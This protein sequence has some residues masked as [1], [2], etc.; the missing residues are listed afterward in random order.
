MIQIDQLNNGIK[1]VFET[2]P[3][4]RSVAVGI[5]IKTG[6]IYEQE[7]N[8]G[9]SHFI[10]HM[11]FKGTKKRSAKVIAE[12]MSAIG[13]HMNAFTAKEY[14][15]FYA[16]TLDEHIYM[17]LD[18]LSDMLQ[19]SLFAEEEI[20]KESTVI[21]DE[22]DM[23]ED[24][25]EEIAHD[26]FQ[27][28]IWE[29]HAL[30]YNI[31][32]KKETVESLDR[33]ELLKYFNHYYNVDNIVISVAGCFDPEEIKDTLNKLFTHVPKAS[34]IDPIDVPQYKRSFAYKDK[35]IEQVHVCLGYPSITYHSE[36]LYTQAIL[37]TILG[38]SMNSKLFQAIREEKGLA[39]SIYSYTSTYCNTGL[40]NIYAASNPAYV[41]D[42][43]IQ[44]KEEVKKLKLDGI[45]ED[46][47]NKT[48]EQLKSNYIIGLESTNSRMSSN[49]KAM[50]TLNRIKTQDEILDQL[51]AVTLND[52]QE[53]G[54]QILDF[55]KLSLSVVGRMKNINIERVR[56]LWEKN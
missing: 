54:N 20:K 31:L 27:E 23:Y 15:C 36:S 10:E 52:F 43:L 5:W 17:A 33:K 22:I 26:L 12:E 42:V 14:T 18:V 4:V 50:C 24:S 53:F 30:G 45:T 19:N 55:N 2:L 11:L 49:G 6:S 9:V 34:V 47:L 16:Q 35:D 21:L 51:N 48:K 3:S 29:G 25:P 1:V 32:G 8:N 38:G 40:L 44:I 13:G 28:K 56:E 41:E 39:Y 7:N 37:N 46:E